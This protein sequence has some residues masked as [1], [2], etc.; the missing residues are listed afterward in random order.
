MLHRFPTCH[1]RP[2]RESLKGTVEVDETFIASRPEAACAKVGRKKNNTTKTLV[3]IAVETLEPKGFWPYQ[4]TA[5]SRNTSNTCCLSSLKRSS[6]A[7][8]YTPMMSA[9]WPAEIR[10]ICTKHRNA[11]LEIPAHIWMPGVHRWRHLSSAGCWVHTMVPYT[12]KTRRTWDDFAS[13]NR[14]L[15]IPGYLLQTIRAAVMTSQRRTR[16]IKAQSPVNA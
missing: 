15:R 3:A 4:T 2:G 6:L 1:G 16:I 5:N 14:E 7:P 13:L 12:R 8:R 11:W 9:Y 10:L